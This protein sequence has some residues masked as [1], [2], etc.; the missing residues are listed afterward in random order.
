[1]PTVLCKVCREQF[2]AKQNWIEKGWGKYCSRKCQFESQKKGKF[3]PCSICGKESWKM[4][5]QLVHSKSGKFFCSKSCQTIWRNAI[6]YVGENH[7]NWKGG[8]S[9]YRKVMLEKTP[10]PICLRCNI[11]EVRVLTVHHKDKN[12]KNN[13]TKNLVW[14]CMNCHH[15]VHHSKEQL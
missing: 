1:M 8:E 4:P 10:K 13:S 12:R 9:T 6:V 2:Y 11:K 15:L 14:L 5:K 3:M 7:S